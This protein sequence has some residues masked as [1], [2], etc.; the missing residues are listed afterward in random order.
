MTELPLACTLGA[1]ALS[2]RESEIRRLFEDALVESRLDGGRLALR[3]QGD[4]TDRVE[5]L[6]A[7]ERECCAFLG[8][9]VGP[10]PEMVIEAPEGAETTLE[11][12]ASLADQA[13]R[14]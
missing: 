6:A 5:A 4:A 14:V 9:S 8:I 3:F 11:G 10:G 2:R 12:F 1:D 13:L 7:A